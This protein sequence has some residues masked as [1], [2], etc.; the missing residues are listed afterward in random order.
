LRPD[1]EHHT[2]FDHGV[3]EFHANGLPFPEKH[4]N[5]FAAI[6]RFRPS[7]QTFI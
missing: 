4:L 7:G 1:T 2:S 3:L 5:G 6:H